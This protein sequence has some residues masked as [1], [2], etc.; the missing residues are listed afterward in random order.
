LLVTCT[1]FEIF[2]TVPSGNFASVK[3]PQKV[4]FSRAFSEKQAAENSI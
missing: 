4:V 2:D 1:H 3:T